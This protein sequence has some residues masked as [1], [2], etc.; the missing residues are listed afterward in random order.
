VDATII[1]CKK[2]RARLRLNILKIIFD[3]YVM[4]VADVIF[5]VSLKRVSP[6]R[7]SP[8]RP[9]TLRISGRSHG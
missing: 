6:M 1:L 5:K 3:I 8:M 7:V 4:S 9:S 2:D